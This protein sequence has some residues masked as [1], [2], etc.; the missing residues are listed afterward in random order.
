MQMCFIFFSHC[1]LHMLTK[2]YETSDPETRLY[3]SE[4]F[5]CANSES[6]LRISLAPQVIEIS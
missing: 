5:W 6:A 1:K 3:F 4:D 2:F